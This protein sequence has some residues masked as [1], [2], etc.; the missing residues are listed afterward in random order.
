MINKISQSQLELEL[1]ERRKKRNRFIH[2]K[3][4]VEF[5][6][7]LMDSQIVEARAILSPNDTIEKKC[8]VS[9]EKIKA[10][11]DRII[12]KK[13]MFYGKNKNNQ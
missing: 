4:N 5:K 3:T 13:E 12:H 6:E 10:K 9:Q 1:K 11:I 8:K 2:P 7:L